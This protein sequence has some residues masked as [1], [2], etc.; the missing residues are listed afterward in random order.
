MKLLITTFIP[1]VA[2]IIATEILFRTFKT[3]I[4]RSS[5]LC[6]AIDR[7]R[8]PVIPCKNDFFFS[9]TLFPHLVSAE[10]ILCLIWKL[11]EIQ[12]VAA[13]FNLEVEAI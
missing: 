3:F 5:T 4:E 13:N 7:S 8:I 2:K 11:L 9:N 10:T 12:I 6:M 1:V